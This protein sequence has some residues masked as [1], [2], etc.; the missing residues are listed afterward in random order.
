VTNSPLINS[1]AAAVE[2]APDDLPLRLHLAELLLEAGD[3][4]A[5][6]A[7]LAQVL[8][9]DPASEPARRLMAG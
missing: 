9:R 4:G 2:A 1:L 3:G 7:H 5:A 8:V 6:V